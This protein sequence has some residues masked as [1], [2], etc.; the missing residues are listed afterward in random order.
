MNIKV[1]IEVDGSQSEVES[2]LARFGLPA[3]K[4]QQA[5]PRASDDGWNHDRAMRLVKRITTS[6]RQALWQMAT[7]APEISFE[8]LQEALA[9]DGVQLGG[10][11]AS[12]GFAQNAGYPRPY[13]AD[14]R[15]RRYLM[16]PATADVFINAIREFETD[17]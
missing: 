14:R 17:D 3:G 15:E 12:F 9:I 10:V 16:D 6:A 13:T 8:R 11:L 1:V 7:N 2:W 4:H 5:L